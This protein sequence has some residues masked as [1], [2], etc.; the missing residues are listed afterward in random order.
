MKLTKNFEMVDRRKVVHI[1]AADLIQ[2]LINIV[3]M[4]FSGI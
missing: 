3:L 4:K 1:A 2:Q